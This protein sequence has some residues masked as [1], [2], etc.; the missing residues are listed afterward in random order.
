MTRDEL[1][2]ISAQELEKLSGD[3]L[4]LVARHLETEDRTELARRLAEEAEEMWSGDHEAPV[5]QA[6]WPAAHLQMLLGMYRDEQREALMDEQRRIASN[7]IDGLE[8]ARRALLCWRF[9]TTVKR[10]VVALVAAATVRA[11]AEGLVKSTSFKEAARVVIDF[12][13]DLQIDEIEDHYYHD[14]AATQVE[15]ASA[16]PPPVEFE[17][18]RRRDSCPTSGQIHTCTPEAETGDNENE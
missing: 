7:V 13:I 14:A 15:A 12:E 6:E 5:P 4:E 16:E 3:E 9:H 17:P 18:S 11:M 10:R 2:A 1:I 8:P